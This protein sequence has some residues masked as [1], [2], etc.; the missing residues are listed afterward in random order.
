MGLLDSLLQGG[1]D[2]DD[3]QDF[4]SR[5]EQGPPYAGISDDEAIGRYQQVAPE[6]S[7][8]VYQ[9]SAQEA[10]SRMAP[11]GRAQFGQLLQQRAGDQGVDLPQ[12]RQARGEQLQ[13]PGMLVQL[14]SGLHQQ[15]PGLLGQLLGGSGAG[16][17]LGGGGVEE[18]GACSA[19]RWPRPPWAGSRPW[20][21]SG[22]CADPAQRRPAA[23]LDLAVHR[24]QQHIGP[25]ADQ[26]E[27]DRA[28]QPGPIRLVSEGPQ[29]GV[30]AAGLVRVEGDRC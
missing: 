28:Q 27:G 23:G 5:Y 18:R 24:F 17:L 8:E 13:D 1:R 11:E 16:G 4:V 14:L 25:V 29:G 6:F 26:A 20:R 9:Q 30:K 19:T 3:Y 12:L 22:C 21:P 15:Q 2:R 7:P 10:L